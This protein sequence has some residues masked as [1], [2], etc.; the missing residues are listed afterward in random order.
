MGL[1]TV[2]SCPGKVLIAGGY[3]VLDPS[4]SGLVV[5]TSSRFY[6]VARSL[7]TVATPDAPLSISVKS[8]QFIDGRWTYELQRNGDEL[9]VEALG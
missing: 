6:T 3:L 5:A 2:V 4:Y 9:L 7:A 8:P 1:E